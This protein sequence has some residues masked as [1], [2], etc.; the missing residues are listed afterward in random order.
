MLSLLF[1][2]KDKHANGDVCEVVVAHSEGLLR[3][4]LAGDA[5]HAFL[6]LVDEE[7]MAGP[8]EGEAGEVGELGGVTH[9]AHGVSI[10]FVYNSLILEVAER[11]SLL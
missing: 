7:T 4:E 10:V 5:S 11:H 2:V 8:D 1:P 3:V 9:F 6:E